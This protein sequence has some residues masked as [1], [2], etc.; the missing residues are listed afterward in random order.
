MNRILS[1]RSNFLLDRGGKTVILRIRLQRSGTALVRH[2]IPP[3]KTLSSRLRGI[4]LSSSVLGTRV[5]HTSPEFQRNTRLVLS[6]TVQGR[7]TVNTVVL[8]ADTIMRGDLTPGAMAAVTY[9]VQD[10]NKVAIRVRDRGQRGRL[11]RDRR[12]EERP[13]DPTSD[14][15]L[16]GGRAGTAIRLI[17]G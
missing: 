9:H 4:D 1:S 16:V 12:P 2:R 7:K 10:S 3:E 8:D 17:G 14:W 5:N 15:R 11:D 6:N 13:P